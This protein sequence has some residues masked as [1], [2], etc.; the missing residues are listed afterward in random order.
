[1]AGQAGQS[2]TWLGPRP[3]AT[4]GPY[5][6]SSALASNG[7]MLRAVLPVSIGELKERNIPPL[8]DLGSD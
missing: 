6:F 5:P 8:P 2:T 3:R 1:M 7:T 4:Q